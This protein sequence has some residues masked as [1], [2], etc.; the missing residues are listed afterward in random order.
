MGVTNLFH[1]PLHFEFFVS[2]VL[3]H[4]LFEQYLNFRQYRF[5]KKKLTG[6][7]TF[8]QEN[9]N[10]RIYKKTLESVSE[11]LNSDDYK[12][13]VEYSYDKLKFNVFNSLFHFLFDLFLLFVLF[14][15]KLWKFSGKVLKKNNEYTQS[16]VF[17]GIKMLF[18]T[19][20]ELPFGLYS[21]FVLEEKHGFNK[22]T[23]KLFVKDLLLTL[24]LQ[25]VI[26]G[27][28]LC[29]LIFLVNWGGEL[30]YFY[31][32]GFIVVFNFIMLIVYPELIAPL[33]NKFEPLHDEEL[34]NDIENL[35]RKVD[36][37][38]KEIKQMDG[39]KRSSHS[40]AYLYGLWKFKKV[41]IYDTLLKQD[42][43]EIVSVVS[44]ELGH[45]KHKHVPK[46][47]TFSFA[48]LFAMFFLFKKF[49][50]NKNMYNSFGFHGV[51][52]FVIGI[53][54]FSNIF[55]VLGIL[56][57]LVNVTL[58]R[59][60]EFQAD[61]YAVKLGYGEDLTKSLLSLH[62]DNKAMIYYDPLYSWY[63]FDHPVLFERLYSLYQTM[64]ERK[65]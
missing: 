38:L 23:Y 57:N 32:F 61:K 48:N 27:P 47:L 19:M 16:L 44:H 58:T 39:S 6:D 59:F 26:G 25:C 13:T 63:H 33:F 53:S 55:T 51:K 9:K 56:T 65:L 2:V 64:A 3:L 20:V 60:H 35:A 21:D 22:K 42:R 43:K 54:L 45:W 46:M 62:K 24:L 34:R 31:V 18:D 10:D 8:L 30:F 12:K 50:D 5:V 17:C 7:K 1:R 28:V 49:K 36:F 29:A 40:N 11:Y 4:E 37:P 15:P 14:S 41:V 52:S